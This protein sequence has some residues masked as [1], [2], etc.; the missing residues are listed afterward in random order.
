MNINVDILRDIAA[1]LAINEQFGNDWSEEIAEL[2]KLIVLLDKQESVKNLPTADQIWDAM[3][4][5]DDWPFNMDLDAP[6]GCRMRL[7]TIDEQVYVFFF[8]KS[9]GSWKRFLF[10]NENMSPDDI[11]KYCQDY[12]YWADHF[13][14]ME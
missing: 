1:F 14:F 2:D 8:D 7:M 11:E 6:L 10:W 4:E 9:T 12:D 13:E 5:Q 3:A